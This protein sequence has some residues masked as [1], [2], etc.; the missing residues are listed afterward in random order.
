[1]KIIVLMIVI[2]VIAL[3][4]LQRNLGLP[5]P[6]QVV[7]IA[8]FITIIVYGSFTIFSVC[9]RFLPVVMKYISP[10]VIHF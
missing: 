9:C 10:D 7:T 4:L 8:F 1:M 5:K 2:L 6:I 3:V